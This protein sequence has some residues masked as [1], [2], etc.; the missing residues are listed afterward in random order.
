MTASQN[1]VNNVGH[2]TLNNQTGTSYTLVIAD[3]GAYL[4]CSNA[5]AITLTIPP[6]SSVAFQI[7]T[8]IQVVQNGAGKITPT[9]GAGVTLNL[10]S[11]LTGSNGQ[12][13]G[14]LLTKVATNTW[15]VVG[16]LV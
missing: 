9:A 8:Q 6:N 1:A 11:G 3:D 5:S 13:T 12:Y 16:N 2:P 10:P 4:R 14:F 7:L 15:D